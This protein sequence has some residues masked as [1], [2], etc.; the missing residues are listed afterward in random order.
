LG[1]VAA[2]ALASGCT[3]APAPPLLSPIEV[4]K[5]YGY[6]EVPLGDDHYQVTYVAPADRTG[7]SVDARA[8]TIAAE[9]KLAFDLAVWRA[10]QL[11]LAQGYAGFKVGNTNSNVYTYEDEP[12]YQPPPWWGPGY[13]RRPYFGGGWG[14][15]WEPSPFLVV[16]VDVTID[17]LMER[18]PGPGDYKA[19]ETIEQLRSIYPGAE[20]ELP[21]TAYNN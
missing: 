19:R 12:F 7:R 5:S 10:A 13:F 6:S 11:A 16:Q 20:G 18:S 8:A 21:P 3:T 2:V 9:R 4:A 14:P 15:Y 1:L 17:V